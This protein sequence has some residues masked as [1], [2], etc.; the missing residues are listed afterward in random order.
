MVKLVRESNPEGKLMRVFVMAVLRC[1]LRPLLHYTM[2]SKLL[3]TWSHFIWVELHIFMQGN[4]MKSNRLV[5]PIC[6]VPFCDFPLNLFSWGSSA[7]RLRMIL[8][9]ERS[10]G[11]NDPR[12]SGILNLEGSSVRLNR[13]NRDR[14]CI[15]DLPVHCQFSKEFNDLFLPVIQLA[16]GTF[17]LASLSPFRSDVSVDYRSKDGLFPV[18]ASRVTMRNPDSFSSSETG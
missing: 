16:T 9:L 6:S 17:H 11:T 18:S 1:P 5:N 7:I 15:L 3:T 2:S 4:D 13:F 10:S 14:S 12:S 8:N